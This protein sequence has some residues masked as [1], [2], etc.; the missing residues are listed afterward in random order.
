MGNVDPAVS[1]FS[2]AV[3]G[4]PGKI[5]STRYNAPCF[6]GG[7]SRFDEPAEELGVGILSMS[8]GGGV[9]VPIEIHSFGPSFL[10]GITIEGTIPRNVGLADLE[11]TLK[12]DDLNY[13]KQVNVLGIF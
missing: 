9:L 13:E 4:C 3:G 5:A 2:P 12:N 1:R 11:I 8:I 7:W 10:K 6:G